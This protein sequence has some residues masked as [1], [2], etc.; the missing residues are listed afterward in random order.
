MRISP[1]ALLC[2]L[3]AKSSNAVLSSFF[4]REKHT[5]PITPL[6]PA[7]ANAFASFSAGV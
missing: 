4:L 3:L 1:I 5:C 6:K 7:S 2:Q